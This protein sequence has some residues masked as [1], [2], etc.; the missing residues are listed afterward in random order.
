MSED[1]HRAAI[2]ALVADDDDQNARLL[3]RILET[4]GYGK[5]ECTTESGKVLPLCAEFHPDLLLLDVSMPSPNGFEILE[6]LAE[7]GGRRPV[8]VMLTGHDHPSI[9]RR[10]ME[11]GAAAVIGK[12]TSRRDLLERLDAM[13]EQAGRLPGDDLGD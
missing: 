12:T 11:L 7:A 2:S 8:V 6:S 3:V 9:K 13:L 1:S 5:I 10:A 4:G